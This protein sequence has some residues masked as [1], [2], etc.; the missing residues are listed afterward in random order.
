MYVCMYVCMYV[1]EH[2]HESGMIQHLSKT[3]Q[4]LLSLNIW[5]LWKIMANCS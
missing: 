2:A 3:P 5:H 1:Y 4:L